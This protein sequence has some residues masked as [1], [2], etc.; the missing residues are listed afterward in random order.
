MGS[1]PITVYIY[2]RSICM[3]KWKGFVMLLVVAWGIIVWPNT[4]KVEAASK[5]IRID[6]FIEYIVKQMGWQ[7]DEKSEQPYIDI[8]I[9]KGILKITTSRII[10]HTLQGLILL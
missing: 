10:K 6:E 2:G 7:I 8:A 1:E 9:E 5:Y 4:Q 3:R